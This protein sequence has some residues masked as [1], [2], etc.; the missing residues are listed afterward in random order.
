MSDATNT[1]RQARRERKFHFHCLFSFLSLL[2]L[3]LSCG[4]RKLCA[5]AYTVVFVGPGRTGGFFLLWENVCF[6]GKPLDSAF[7][8]LTIYSILFP[9]LYC[10]HNRINSA[11]LLPYY[12]GGA[13]FSILLA[14]HPPA[15]PPARPK[16]EKPFV[17][18]P[19]LDLPRKPPPP[20]PNQ[21]Q[22]KVP[23]GGLKPL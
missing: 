16:I 17:P 21:N 19:P 23:T 15:H 20:P 9:F 5:R 6:R 8:A 18:P 4:K 10:L 12:P 14:K 22:P 3:P 1:F 2:T 7:L 13:I 11:Q